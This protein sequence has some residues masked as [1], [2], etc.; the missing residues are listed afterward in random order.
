M[1]SARCAS[2]SAVGEVV[3]PDQPAQ[4]ADAAFGDRDDPF[5][6]DRRIARQVIIPGRTG[7]LMSMISLIAC[8]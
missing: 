1:S 5:E 3:D 8:L 7:M 6:G 2:S 4:V